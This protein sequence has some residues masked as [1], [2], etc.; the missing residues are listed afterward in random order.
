MTKVNGYKIETGR[1]RTGYFGS[2]FSDRWHGHNDA[3]FIARG[4]RPER[5]IHSINDYMEPGAGNI[6]LGYYDDSRKAAYVAAMY[7]ADPVA[8]LENWITNNKQIK[9]EFPEELFNLPERLTLADAQR[10]LA[11]KGIVIKAKSGNKVP[12]IKVPAL[13]VKSQEQIEREKSMAAVWARRDKAAAVVKTNSYATV[14]L[15]KSRLPSKI[16]DLIRNTL[17]N[18]PDR[19]NDYDSGKRFVDGMI[20]NAKMKVAA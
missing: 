9:V 12:K 14:A 11:G 3:P 4:D 17:I 1:G 6:H 13:K 10:L 19:F 5:N 18:N 8:M 16:Q 15:R 2:C 20:S 7:K